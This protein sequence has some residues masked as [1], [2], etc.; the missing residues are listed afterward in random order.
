LVVGTD[1]D[2]GNDGNDDVH[3]VIVPPLLLRLF[4]PGLDAEEGKPK[5]CSDRLECSVI[6]ISGGGCRCDNPSG[7]VNRAS[8]RSN[9]SR[10]LLG[11][12][13]VGTVVVVVVV[14]AVVATPVR[15]FPFLPVND[16]DGILVGLVAYF[17]F[18]LVRYDTITTM[19]I[20]P[21]T[22]NKKK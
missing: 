3:G 10:K 9:F 16:G 18:G 8:S 14:V 7:C 17:W 19:R 5:E 2:N 11:G 22:K 21:S 15:S 12:S 4:P 1:D 20:D 13:I 6:I